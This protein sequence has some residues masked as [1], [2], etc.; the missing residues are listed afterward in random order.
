MRCFTEGMCR[1]TV[2]GSL[3]LV[4]QVAY[5]SWAQLIHVT[6]NSTM[7]K[8]P[9]VH[10]IVSQVA[11]T[12]V[13]VS[14]TFPEYYDSAGSYKTPWLIEATRRLK[15]QELHDFRY[16]IDSRGEQTIDLPHVATIE[17]LSP[18]RVLKGEVTFT[19]TLVAE[20]AEYSY[21]YYGFGSDISDGGY[22]YV[23]DI[24]AYVESLGLD[25][26]RKLRT[27]L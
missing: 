21:M 2:V 12:S 26:G 14:A 4:L 10:V 15:E 23:V 6:P 13:Q 1:S 18:E 3:L 19:V 25:G 20:A 27:G 17:E 16:S 5:G 7:G 22:Y 24:P 8:G 11:P 9:E